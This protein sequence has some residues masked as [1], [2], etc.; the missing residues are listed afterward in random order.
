MTIDIA[1]IIIG[2]GTSAIAR[3][4]IEEI[5]KNSSKVIEV[6]QGHYRD[7]N[8]EMIVYCPENIQK[9]SIIFEARGGVLP[10]KIRFPFGKPR[11]VKL[12]PVNGNADLSSSVTI[13]DDGFELNTKKLK[14]EDLFILDYEYRLKN[15]QFLDALVEKNHAKEIPTDM[16]SEFWIH[17]ELKHPNILKTKYGKLELQD[18][19]F[20]IDVGISGDIKT[21]IPSSFKRELEAAKM[22]VKEPDTHKKY[23]L[24][25]NHVYMMRERGKKE[26][27]ITSLSH[28]QE[29]FFPTKFCDYIDVTK[30]FHYSNCKQGTNYYDNLPFASWP[31]TMT[32]ISRADLNL[33]KFAAAGT[34]IYHKNDFLAKVAEILGN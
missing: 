16:E 6:L 28:L 10:Q 7:L 25:M 26:D 22:L 14:Q 20:N 15:H 8:R 3:K 12:R 17:A 2:S 13:T 29:L 24:G 32:V 18:I 27:V 5:L 4:G 19:D 34:V 9:N 1:S 31:K 23:R 11:R 33:E 21:V 30:D